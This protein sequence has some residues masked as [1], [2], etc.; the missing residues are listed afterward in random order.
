[1]KKIYKPILFS[2]LASVAVASCDSYEAPELTTV[3]AISIVSRDVSFPAAASTGTIQFT[4][5]G[6]VTVSTDNSWITASVEGDLIKVSVT[7]NDNLMSRAG[8]IVAKCGNR[9]T[10]ISIIQ[11]G[12]VFA[13]PGTEVLSFASEASTQI[14]D[15][16]ANAPVTASSNVDWIT[17]AVEDGA[18][19]VSVTDNTSI[20]PREGSFTVTYGDNTASVPVQQNGFYIALFDRTSWN[21][22]GTANS[23]L[24]YT[25]KL[26]VAP[27]IT[28]DCDWITYTFDENTKILKFTA[29]KNTT[30]HVRQGS[31]SYDIAGKQGT[32]EVMQCN[33]ATDLA[34]DQYGLYFTKPSD[35]K[36]YYMAATLEKVGTVYQ[37]TLPKMGI[38]IP[39][40]YSTVNYTFTL[41]GGQN[42]G[43]YG[44]YNVFTTF[45][46]T[47][48]GKG[49]VTWDTGATMIGEVGYEFDEEDNAGYTFIEFYDGGTYSVPLETLMLYA[50]SSTT[51]SGDTALGY[52]Q[53]MADPFLMRIDEAEASEAPVKSPRKVTVSSSALRN[54]IQAE[55]VLV[56]DNAPIA[57]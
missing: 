55:P 45:G 6:A 14:I 1:M 7:Q 56:K 32:V 52:L 48:E 40:T 38:S 57:R 26:A 28:T 21:M 44:S 8:V 16:K 13:I 10:D 11:D 4:S 9:T 39:L 46:F 27:E 22:T 29:A 18:L 33:F 35:G 12:Q 51:L 23:T 37:I 50:F 34:S 36:L 42:C 24:S 54:A 2:L 53:W 41:K 20:D 25:Y 15:F 17:A 49:K 31:F 5:E 43:K 47:E 30:G 3:P 19:K